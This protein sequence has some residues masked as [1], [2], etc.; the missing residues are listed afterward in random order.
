[1]WQYNIIVPFLRKTKRFLLYGRHPLFS[2]MDKQCKNDSLLNKTIPK[3]FITKLNN[4]KQSVTEE[5]NDEQFDT[6]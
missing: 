4:P 1:M 2:K 3:Q 6:E 5:N